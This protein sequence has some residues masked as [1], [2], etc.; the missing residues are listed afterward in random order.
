[1]HERG[2]AA[3]RELAPAQAA[4]LSLLVE[5][6]AGWQNLRKGPSRPPEATSVTQ[7]LQGVQ[8]AY[9]A[10][11]SKLVAYNKRYAPAHVPELLLNT[12]T[13]L[14]LWCRTMQEVFLKAENQPRVPCPVELVERA[15][16]A[17]ER[18]GIRL[19]ATLPSRSG[20]PGTVRA[21]M[22]DLAA[23]AQWCDGLVAAPAVTT[24]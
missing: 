8:R 13:R 2:E 6:E 20:P 21:A 12:P 11:H 15:Y 9:D 16:R 4:E 3:V 10:F 1:M 19:N 17:A 23:L 7:T 22:Q 5:L 24:A 14:A 18:I